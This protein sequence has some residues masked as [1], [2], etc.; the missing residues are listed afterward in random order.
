MQREKDA[1]QQNCLNR[2]TARSW[3]VPSIPK[4]SKTRRRLEA[5]W[6]FLSISGN[7]DSIAFN[8]IQCDPV[9][10]AIW[11]G[12][13]AAVVLQRSGKVIL[14]NSLYVKTMD[15][16]LRLTL[17]LSTFVSRDEFLRCERKTNKNFRRSVRKYLS[18][19]ILLDG[20]TY[21]FARLFSAISSRFVKRAGQQ[22]L[23]NSFLCWKLRT[24][25]FEAVIK[26]SFF[27]MSGTNRV[28][29]R[30]ASFLFLSLFLKRSQLYLVFCE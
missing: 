3:A 22:D 4:G 9:L 1:A 6:I 23:P 28:L 24:R 26:R 10:C 16:L 11:S 19:L 30:F 15:Q 17:L 29:L 7:R 27:Y 25:Y 13:C 20:Y 2:K 5:L 14:L 21:R 8:A 18:N 12:L